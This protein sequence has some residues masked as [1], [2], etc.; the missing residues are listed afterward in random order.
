MVLLSCLPIFTAIL[1]SAST[2]P[3]P[4]YS[5]S[6]L[7]LFVLLLLLVCYEQLNKNLSLFHVRLVC[8]EEKLVAMLL[9]INM[10]L[11]FFSF[12][13]RLLHG[14]YLIGKYAVQF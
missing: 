12:V 7:S 9:A 14:C 11:S 4:S 3:S 5:S 10:M 8:V 6:S 13:W 1:T 2:P